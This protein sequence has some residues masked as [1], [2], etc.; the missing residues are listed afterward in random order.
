MQMILYYS[1]LHYSIIF[2]YSLRSWIHH[3]C[4]RQK[5][6]C[7][8]SRHTYNTPLIRFEQMSFLEKLRDEVSQPSEWVGG[9]NQLLC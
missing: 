4:L 8:L 5:M 3:H 7:G 6:Q 1:Y 9:L 2:Q